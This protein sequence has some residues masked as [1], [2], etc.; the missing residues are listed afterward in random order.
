MKLFF[1]LLTVLI[2][3]QTSIAQNE[4]QS[5]IVGR[6]DAIYAMNDKSLSDKLVKET[7]RTR[8]ASNSNHNILV[9][10]FKMDGKFDLAS[11]RDYSQADEE[12]TFKVD[13]DGKSLVR[14][15]KKPNSL[16]AGLRKRLKSR[17]ARILYL[18]GD[19]LVLKVKGEIL[20]LKRT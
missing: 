7:K 6:W 9:V 20:Y 19:V 10:K 17:K 5:E 16:K 1:S 11:I 8:V 2:L 3:S 12:G 15:T 13:K 18:E 14:I 4:V